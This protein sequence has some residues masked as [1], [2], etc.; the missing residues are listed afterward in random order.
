MTPVDVSEL[1]ARLDETLPL[2]ARRAGEAND[3]RRPSPEVI[4]AMAERGLLRLIVPRS[5]GGLEVE[6]WTFLALVERL[7]RVDGSTAWTVMTLNEEAGIASA[8]LHPDPVTELFTDEPSTIVAGSGV[9]KGRAQEVEGG[10]LVTGRWD[11]VSGCTASDRVVL[12]TLV[13]GTSPPELCF[14]LIPTDEVTIEDTWRTSGLRGTGSND[15]VLDRHFVPDRW[16]GVIE[17][18]GLPRPDTPFY[19]LPSGLRFPF[20][21]VG[22]A[23]G[24]AGAALDEFTALA[25]G[26]RPLFNKGNLR[27]RPTAQQAFAEAVA[28]RSAGLAWVNEVLDELWLVAHDGGPIPPAL[29]AR[30]RLASSHAVAASIDAVELVCREA[31]T[32]ANFASSPLPTLL[33][34]A[35]AVAGHFMVAPYQMSTAG[36]ILLGLDADDPHF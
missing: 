33:A 10:W 34:D 22:V 35:R 32:T 26:K 1:E 12:S 23:A 7:A 25:E 8:Y 2:V 30:V 20:P 24:I 9:P 19:R 16:A 31:G 18:Y 21:K 5:Y 28:R 27:E 15:V 17:S 13:D 3:D 14:V 36:R 11:F 4:A 6:P 29:H